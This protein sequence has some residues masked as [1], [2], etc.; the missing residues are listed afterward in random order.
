MKLVLIG[1]VAGIAVAIPLTRLMSSLFYGVHSIDPLTYVGVSL[2]LALI[3]LIASYLP[4]LSATK[5]DP[6]ITLRGES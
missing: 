4:A 1:I 5:V 2:F 3:A 6:A